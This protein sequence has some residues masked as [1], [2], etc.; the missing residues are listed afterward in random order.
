MASPTAIINLRPLHTLLNPKFDGYKLSLDPVPVLKTPLPSPLRRVYTNDDQYTFLHAKLFS[1]HNHLFRD[2]WLSY[3]SYFV[4]DT[5]TI[6]NVRYDTTT[7]SLGT[8]KS[9]LKLSKPSVGHNDYNP[10]CCFVSE[11]YCVF[12]DGCG[13]VKIIDTGDRFRNDEWKTIHSAPVF[14]NSVPFVI[15]DARLESVDGERHINC[16]L[17]S[18]QEKAAGIDG[19]DDKRYEAVI[20]W[21]RFAKEAELN[22]WTKLH[23]RRLCGKSLPEYCVLD[24]KSNGILLST[25]QSFEFVFDAE[26]PLKSEDPPANGNHDPVDGEINFTWTQT[27]EDVMVHFKVSRDSNKKDFK[28]VCS[29]SKLQVYHRNVSLLDAELCSEI[30]N[31]LTTWNLVICD[32]VARLDGRNEIKIGSSHSFLG[33]RNTSGDFGEIGSARRME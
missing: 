32:D 17:L 15:Q 8:I 6:Q 18:V 31:D 14:E 13:T 7:G 16:L 3:S 23:V 29:K 28:I 4:D 11:K 1:L 12:S 9:V 30:D 10:S 5:W 22:V 24:V 21:V 2:P 27:D 19:D 25:D 20:D 26:H 33:K